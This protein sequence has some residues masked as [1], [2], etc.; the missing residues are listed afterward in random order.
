MAAVALGVGELLASLGEGGQSLVIS[1]DNLVIDSTPG[2]AA[3]AGIELFGTADKP[4][5]V[6]GTVVVAL[7]FGAVLGI[8]SR[9]RRWVGTLGFA[10]FATLGAVAATVDDL[11]PAGSSALI[12]AVAAGAG[13]ATLMFLLAVAEGRRPAPAAAAADEVLAPSAEA[14]W[15]EQPTRKLADRRAFFGWAGA[16]GVAALATAG[17]GRVLSGRSRAEVVRVE[18]LLPEPTT[19]APRLRAGLEGDVP[20]LSPLIT[21]NEDFY[22]IDTALIV[23]QIDPDR[24]ELSI[25]GLVEEPYSIG[26]EELLGM[27]TDEYDVTL[28]CVSNEVGG[29]LVGTARW[30]GV[31]LMELL[32]RAGAKDGAE[33]VVGRSVDGWTSGFPIDALRDGRPAVVA[34]GM[35]GEPLPISHGFPARLV[36][37]GLYGYVSATKWLSE[38]ELT[39]WDDFDAYWVPRGW[40]KEGPMKT[41]SRVDVPRDGALPA[42]GYPGH[43]RRGV[44]RVP[45][46]PA[47]GGPGRRRALGGGS[48][49][50]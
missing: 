50:A 5:L 41:Q 27:A 33:Q 7:L 28:S 30:Q 19:A 18:V 23:P 24:W 13:A 45:R 40:S 3:R 4:L 46:D 16:A 1:V 25:T 22:R 35:N 43:S 12:A 10:A 36:V 47:G 2:D 6:G 49:G 9:S 21:P 37:G 17:A 29:N 42:V 26:F 32:D 44:G 38:I 8:A 14:A 39:R 31:P 15:L 20:G 34:V 11:A 48:T